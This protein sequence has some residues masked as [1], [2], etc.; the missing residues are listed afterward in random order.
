[1]LNECY[2][3]LFFAVSRTSYTN[4]H[5]SV[6]IKF[7]HDAWRIGDFL[8]WGTFVLHWTPGNEATYIWTV[9][10]LFKVNMNAK[11][12]HGYGNFKWMTQRYV[13]GLNS[14][15]FLCFWCMQSVRPRVRV[16][17]DKIDKKKNEKNGEGMKT[18]H[19]LLVLLLFKDVKTYHTCYSVHTVAQANVIRSKKQ[20]KKCDFSSLQQFSKSQ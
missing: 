5:H 18:R 14:K 11:Q 8:T 12:W 19:T 2:W 16:R 4:T 20:N 3:T 7:K 6:G 15:P 17:D 10:I 13:I 9:A 1:M